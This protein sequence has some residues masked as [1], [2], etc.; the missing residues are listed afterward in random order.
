MCD[1]TTY[2]VLTIASTMYSTIQADANA[3]AQEDYQN[4]LYKQNALLANQ[5]AVSQYAELARRQVQEQAAAAQ[6]V[7]EVQR[8]S[9]EATGTARVSAGEAGVAGIS[10][11]A[12]QADFARQELQYQ[13][14]VI[15]NQRFRNQQ[16]KA[17]G[18]GIQSQAQGRILSALPQPV[19]KPDFFGAALRIG[20]DLV[21]G[22]NA[23]TT[24]DPNTKKRVWKSNGQ[25]ASIFGDDS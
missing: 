12:L 21:E 17:E 2:A 7:A 5:S 1:F 24:Y 23:F 15:V 16:F 11:D 20:G 6:G 18:E 9:R 13:T 4:A 3:E 8:R 14:S 22:Y 10:V 25:P 19:A